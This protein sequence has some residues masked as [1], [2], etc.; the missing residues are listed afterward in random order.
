[1]WDQPVGVCVIL[2]KEMTSTHA[3]N[4]I[5]TLDPNSILLSEHLIVCTV[6]LVFCG[7]I[8]MPNPL[9]HT[10]EP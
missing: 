7:S 5:P 3:R 10:E 8:N 6:A 2:N 1:M 4:L 9:K